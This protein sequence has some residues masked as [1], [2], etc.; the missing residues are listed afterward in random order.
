M[1]PLSICCTTQFQTVGLSGM[2]EVQTCST[3]CIQKVP[4][5][6]RTAIVWSQCQNAHMMTIS[7]RVCSGDVGG[8]QSLLHQFAHSQVQ[9]EVT[10]KVCMLPLQQTLKF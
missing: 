4:N 9:T 1:Q 7:Q 3:S 2:T 5:G 8:L 6:A 10:D